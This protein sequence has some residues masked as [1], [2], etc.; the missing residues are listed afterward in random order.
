M[1]FKRKSIRLLMG[2]LLIAVMI[3][4]SLVVFAPSDAYADER[5]GITNVYGDNRYDTSIQIAEALKEE[6]GVSRFD[7][8]VVARGDSYPDALSGGYLASKYSAPLIIVNNNNYLN[9][10]NYIRTNLR[11]GGTI[12][13]LGGTYAISSSLEMSLRAI[14]PDV[15][16][17]SGP[18]RYDTNLAILKESFS[19]R[20]DLLICS[21]QNFPD[22]LSAS[23]AGRPIMLVGNSLTADQEEFIRTHE[24]GRLYIIGGTAAVNTTVENQISKY[25]IPTRIYGSNRYGTAV[26]V[27]N[28][29]YPTSTEVTFA[30]G[31]NFPDG[32]CG[33]VLSAKMNA[34]LLL[35]AQDNGFITAYKY[36]VENNRIRHATVFGGPIAVSDDAT[37]LRKNSASRKLGLLSIGK[38]VYCTNSEGNLLQR[39]FFTVGGKKYY[40]SK[41]GTVIRNAAFLLDEQYYGAREDGS[42]VESG[43]E[44]TGSLT[45]YFDNYNITSESLAAKAVLDKAGRNLESAYNW[46]REL[47]NYEFTLGRTPRWGI[48]YFANYGFVS[49]K[50]DSYVKAATFYY[51]AKLLGYDAN[52][53]YGTAMVD[54]ENRDHAWVEIKEENIRYIYDPSLTPGWRIAYYTDYTSYL[55]YGNKTTMQME[56]LTKQ[57]LI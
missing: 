46:S 18:T 29:F 16:R 45:Y 30:S 54:G 19:N 4:S 50:G 37:A 28:L 9:A 17:L 7:A 26:A 13:L 11:P 57:E 2:G 23:G 55:R 15:M 12:F 32:L 47:D 6:L 20:N 38:E 53:V 42:L 52:M 27:A 49:G 31:E 44:K 41:N 5:Y 51:M 25:R 24:F 48:T 35:S 21:G 22:A 34:P 33:G 36:V 14:T 8:V 1:G 39:T 3:F 56:D 43:W 10:L 40:A